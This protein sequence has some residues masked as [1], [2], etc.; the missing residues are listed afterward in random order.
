MVLTKA[1]GILP[2]S[3]RVRLSIFVA[4]LAGLFAVPA[5]ASA[6]CT[7]PPASDDESGPGEAQTFSGN[8]PGAYRG[9]FIQIPFEVGADV[10]GMRISYCY[11]SDG[12]DNMTGGAN[13]AD[14]TTL[15]LGVY[16]PNTASPENW[17]MDQ[18]RGWSGSAIKVV[19]I[20]ENGH[21]TNEIYGETAASRDAYVP[22]NTTRAYKPGPIPQ[23]T[24]AVELGAGYI[25]DEP[26]YLTDYTVEIRTSTA[27]AWTDENF[28]P[29]PYEP[30]V[31]NPAAG[32][33][34]GD[35]HVHGENEPGNAPME[36]TFDLGFGPVGLDFMTLVDHNNDVA[37]QTELG[38]YD[39]DYPGKLIIPGTE[40]TTYD[41]HFNSQNSDQFTDFRL[42][43]ILRFDD[44][45]SNRQLDD[46]ELTSVRGPEDPSTRFAQ[47]QGAGGWSQINHPT[48]F[49]DAP[50]SCRGCAWTYSDA[51]TDF[52][53]VNAIEIVTGPPGI[54]A[55]SPTGPSVMNPFVTTAIEYYEHALSTGAHVAAVATSDDHKAQDIATGLAETVLGKG[56]TVVHADELSQTGVTAAVKAGHTYV[57]SFGP[58]TPDVELKAGEPG[59]AG[60]TRLPGDSVTAPAMNIQLN[61]LEAGPT[62]TVPGPYTIE[63]LKNGVS[64]DSAPVVGDAFNHELNVTETGRYSF[65]LSR[66]AGPNK[67]I[68][69]YSTPVWFTYKAPS[70]K[71]GFQGLKLNRKKGTATLKVR[72]PGKGK[73]ALLGSKTVK[74]QKKTAK[75]KSTVSI[76]IKARGRAA[77]ALKRKGVAK[78][79]A[80]VRFTPAGGKALTKSK[81]VKLVKKKAGKKP[82]KR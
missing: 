5:V 82:K 56:A 1:M 25:D 81:T 68:M 73:V 65:Q 4:V 8:L 33:Y 3:F 62:A 35:L 42:S 70:N 50:A 74:G 53:K 43:E 66:M 40:M 30:Y 23:G 12:P 48:T 69:A 32:W 38:D 49:K 75:K 78:V 55:N 61:V 58:D 51:D 46:G 18:R 59:K 34:T 52:T 63:I 19:G 13:N 10:T 54:P 15:D 72:V 47:I 31:A 39:E 44:A 6:T 22:G 27:A 17:T 26:G 37:R 57:K 77:K 79:R 9:K 29:S 80:K 67:L 45:N 60:P 7:P 11:D 14:N 36:D 20:G 21:T 16:E 64:I 2:A 24:W 76:T 41:G 71:F 28:E